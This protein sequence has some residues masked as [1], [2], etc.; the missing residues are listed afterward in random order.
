M[1]FFRVIFVICCLATRLS[2]ASDGLPPV[3]NSYP[4][5]E[6]PLLAQAKA[7][8]KA[9]VLADNIEETKQVLLQNAIIK[10]RQQAAAAGAD[11]VILTE[12]Q[13]VMGNSQSLRTLRHSGYELKYSIAGELISLCQDDP[14]LDTVHTP[15]SRSG[16]RQG[17]TQQQAAATNIQFEISIPVKKRQASQKLPP[18]AQTI[19]LIQGFYGAE[20]GMSTEQVQTLFGMPDATLALKNDNMAWIYGQEHLVMFAG[21]TA[22]AFQQSNPILSAEIKMRLLENLRFQQHN[23]QLDNRFGRRTAIADIQA[24]Y[25]GKLIQLDQYRF[26]L[27]RKDRQLILE[28]APYLDVQS[29][30]HQL[31][32][33]SLS[34][35]SRPFAVD[36]VQLKLPPSDALQ[37]LKSSLAKMATLAAEGAFTIPQSVLFNRSQLRDGNEISVL[38]PVLALSY[39][40]NQV[41]G[42]T[43]TNI[44]ANYAINDIQQQLALLD[45]PL[46]RDDFMARFPNAFDSLSQLTLY[47][48][49]IEIKATYNTDDLIDSLNISWY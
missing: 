8:D 20:P 31:Q 44:T 36:T 42:L 22:V 1:L 48:D 26:A 45:L 17:Q 15:Y 46:T 39:N 3:L 41:V 18:L 38:S 25:Q 9:I 10:I 43:V 6:Y 32:L 7:S 37:P 16:T 27:Q 24:F 13:G 14:S 34:L 40:D 29:N 19:S 33:V 49:N 30:K 5:C 23:W 2:Y 47:G 35:L 21:N 28:F 12:V 4:K 11:A